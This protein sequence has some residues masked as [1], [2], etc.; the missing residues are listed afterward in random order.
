MGLLSFFGK[1]TFSHGIHPAYH[2]AETAGLK[3]RRLP[4]PE[5]LVIPLNQHIGKPSIPLVRRGQEVVR[6]EP[7]AEADGFVSVPIHAPASGRIRDI[8]L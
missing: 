3:S 8:R 2:K 7:I 6:G 5:Q 4:F 1:G